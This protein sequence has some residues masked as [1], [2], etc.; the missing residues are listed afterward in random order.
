MRFFTDMTRSSR[1]L[2]TALAIAVAHLAGLQAPAAFADPPPDNHHHWRNTNY[3]NHYVLYDYASRQWVETID[4][5]IAYRFNLVRNEM[6]AIELHDPSRGMTIR[7]TYDGM[8]LKAAGAAGFSFYQNGTF[9]RRLRFEHRD[10]AGQYTGAISKQ[11]AC[12]WVEYLAGASAPTFRFSHA[13]ANASSVE[14]YDGSRDLWVRLDQTRMYLRVGAGAYGY[15][16][17]GRW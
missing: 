6:N 3:A 8:Y 11:H 16:K 9:D 13:S 15:F 1:S 2:V 17:D 14:M 10:A 4:C 12:Q 7:L 5:R